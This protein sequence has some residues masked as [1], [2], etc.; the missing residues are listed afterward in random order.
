MFRP[1]TAQRSLKDNYLVVTGWTTTTP[2][3]S[4]V[5]IPGE[6]KGVPGVCQ[7]S[8]TT[9]VSG[10][11]LPVRLSERCRHRNKHLAQ[12]VDQRRRDE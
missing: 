2:K 5:L 9:A 10:H 6:R 1:M 7:G 11:L 12:R 3:L 4:F 8:R